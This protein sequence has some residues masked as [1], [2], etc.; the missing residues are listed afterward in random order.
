MVGALSTLEGCH[1]LNAGQRQ[2]LNR[3]FFLQWLFLR[4]KTKVKC[5]L[6]FD[7]NCEGPFCALTV[8]FHFQTSFLAIFIFMCER[9]FLRVTLQMV[10]KMPKEK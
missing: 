3:S 9:L 6:S 4:A 8:V 2:N 1:G 7:L 5:Q 10:L